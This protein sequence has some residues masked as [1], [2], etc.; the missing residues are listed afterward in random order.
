MNSARIESRK[1]PAATITFRIDGELHQAYPGDTVAAALYAAG[2]R[3]W[4]RSRAGDMRGLLCG[5][6]VCFDCL[7]TVDGA[8]NMRACQV[9]V[10]D[11][12]EI[13]TGLGGGG[14]E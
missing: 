4:R 8:A 2:R 3:A 10:R 7:V 13:V 6:G 5:M 14:S 1:E 12:M 11:G 9:L